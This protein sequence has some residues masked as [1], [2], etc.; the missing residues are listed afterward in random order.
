MKKTKKMGLGEKVGLVIWFIG[1]AAIAS[2]VIFFLGA[3]TYAVF[4][5][6]VPVFSKMLIIGLD[7]VL[8]GTAI[9]EISRFKW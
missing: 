2:C 4:F 6:D 9:I 3:A 5:F 8:M 1:I 7:G